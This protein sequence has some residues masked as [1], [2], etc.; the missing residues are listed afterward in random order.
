MDEIIDDYYSL[1][2]GSKWSS[3]RDKTPGSSSCVHC[4]HSQYYNGNVVSYDCVE[5][6]RLYVIRYLPAHA[7]EN[8]IAL[9]RISQANL[10]SWLQRDVIRILSI[11]GG[12]G[13]DLYSALQFI[14]Q[15][16]TNATIE[17]TR[18]DIQPLWDVIASDIIS[19]SVSR[20][21]YT[22][23]TVHQDALAGLSR[24]VHGSFNLIICSYFISEVPHASFQR[25]GTQLRSLLA[26]DGALLINDRSEVLVQQNIDTVYQSAQLNKTT[27]Y[28]AGW[29]G[30]V[31]PEHIVSAVA[32]KFNMSSMA[33]V[34]EV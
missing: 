16:Q 34:G 17:V 28:N 1:L 25:L 23:R 33:S 15:H 14:E 27:L 9:G 29:A 12:P 7:G 22:E 20:L 4:F 32:P 11:G 24:F 2:D 19:R 5:K 26:P 13:S 3:C 10:D 8:T 21:R 31:F 6:R 18:L 30:F